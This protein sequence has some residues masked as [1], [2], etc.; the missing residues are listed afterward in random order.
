MRTGL[1]SVHEVEELERAERAVRDFEDQWRR[2][3]PD[4]SKHWAESDC[5]KTVSVLAALVKVD[6]RCRYERGERPTVADYFERYPDLCEHSDRVI[7]LVYEE[8]CLCEEQGEQPNPEQFCDRYDLWRDSLASQL[9]YHRD[10]SQ[11]VGAP[12]APPQFPVEGDRFEQFQLRS[13]MGQGGSARVFRALDDSMGGREVVLKISA[14]RG[15]EPSIMGKLD[16]M[17][18]VP[19][20]RVAM[21]PERGLRG[22]SMPFRPGLPLDVIIKKVNP[23]SSPRGALAI[24]NA[25]TPEGSVE[26][27]PSTSQSG[28]HTFPIRGSYVEGVAWIVAMLAEALA[29]S[30]IKGILHRD[31]KPANVLLTLSNGPQLLDFNLAHDPHS[32]DQARAA[33]RGGTLPYMAPEQL[34]AYLDPVQWDKVGAAAELYSLGLL[35]HEL[36]TGEPPE[37][38]DQKLPPPRA[39]RALL[40]SRFEPRVSP[41]YL[42]PAVP[43]ALEGIVARCLRFAPEDRY[44]DAK[45]LADDLQRFL[46]HQPLRFAS[47][48]SP[49]ERFNN[50]IRRS[51]RRLILFATLSIVLIVLLLPYIE[52]LVPIVN[53]P[54]FQQAIQLISVK[55]NDRAIPLLESLVK[56]YPDSALGF[57]YLGLAKEKAGNDDA[58]RTNYT[59]ALGLRK[60]MAE[61]LAWSKNEPDIG[62]RLVSVGKFLTEMKV[63]PEVPYRALQIAVYVNPRLEEAHFLIASEQ[64]RLGKHALA[65]ERLTRIINAVESRQ[66]RSDRLKLLAWYH[67]RALVSL[68]WGDRSRSS[69]LP[70]GK[71]VSRKL[72]QEALKDIQRGFH[73]LTDNEIDRTNRERYQIITARVEMALGDLEEALDRRSAAARHFILARTLIEGL[74]P[75]SKVRS[76]FDIE[77]LRKD[78]RKRFEAPAPRE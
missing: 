48:A 21:Q 67:E 58:A 24:W 70:D 47:N 49:R 50:W 71:D 45:A 37:V 5:D 76:E 16:H 7:S 31:V 11:V 52:Q 12:L 29:Y 19:V 56:Q 9:R 26:L 44:P 62:H 14:D 15:N 53:R 78:L 46:E 41:R 69:N 64:S 35:M 8:F 33:L 51:W 3:E 10:F 39:I 18:I 73:L 32:A 42:N 63:E 38:P 34:E 22:L 2:G 60:A 43:H 1:A 54:S 68:S 61:F 74:S 66:A 57:L 30:H 23:A 59:K 55:Q 17:H 28:W 13:L 72:Y 40:D 25:L 36:L 20:L 75:Q 6:L 4:L 27:K 77:S 65:F